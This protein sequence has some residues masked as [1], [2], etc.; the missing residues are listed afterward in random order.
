[1]KREPG[2]RRRLSGPRY[3]PLHL[4]PGLLAVVVALLIAAASAAFLLDGHLDA[5]ANRNTGPAVHG[6]TGV[7]PSSGPGSASDSARPSA[8]AS[9]DSDCGPTYT[10]GSQ[11]FPNCADTGVPA[12]TSLQRMT[13]PEPTG[14]GT[15]NVTEVDQSGTVINGVYLTGSLD[16]YANNVTI[17][18]SVIMATSWWGI[19]L[20][21]GYSH[22]RVL[23]CT[24]VGV[25]GKGPDNGYEDYGVDSA[26]GYVEVGWSNIYGFGDEIQLG[27]G[28][29]HDNYVH[30]EASWIPQ[31][32]SGYEHLDPFLSTGGSG[33]VLEHNTLLDPWSPARGA[34]S[35]LGLFS[36]FAPITDVTVKD[37]FLAGGAYALYPGGGASS[38]NVVIT[39]NVFSTMYWPGG[40][41]YGAVAGSLW[42][43]GGGNE[44]SDNVWAN[45]PQA[46]Q[47][48]E[49]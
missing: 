25:A 7:T 16:V 32:S 36:D 3:R 43:Y 21:A 1:M 14:E 24:I 37:N 2:K 49:P 26:G 29:V 31:G 4:R 48:I 38:R 23:H 42:H 40:G 19:N 9:S 41:Y 6:S 46:G 35:S 22:L 15:G 28:Y 13:S 17:E 44:W 45:G 34:S 30:G 8:S 33:L 5:A 11:S 39:G 20:R 12:G 10:A 18:N 27:I 47:Q